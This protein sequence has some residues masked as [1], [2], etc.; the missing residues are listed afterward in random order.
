MPAPLSS[1]RLFARLFTCACLCLFAATALAVPG[2]PTAVVSLDHA[3]GVHLSWQAPSGEVPAGYR[4]YRVSRHEVPAS[5]SVPAESAW[6]LQG[7][8]TDT[9]WTQPE[10]PI[11]HSYEY[12]VRAHDATGQ[13]GPRSSRT[14][15]AR[16]RFGFV[17]PWNDTTPSPAFDFRPAHDARVRLTASGSRLLRAGQPIR[18]MGVNICGAAA[19]PEAAEAAVVA[20]RMALFGIN[21]VRFHQIDQLQPNGV[22]SDLALTQLS[23]TQMSRLGGFI[24]ALA[25][26]GIYTNLNLHVSRT[27]LSIDP[28]PARQRFKGI[29]IF[30]HLAGGEQDNIRKQQINYA[31]LFLNH[32]IPGIGR[33][34]DHPAVSIVEINNENGLI[35]QWARGNFDRLAFD[36][37]TYHG[38]LRDLWTDWLRKRYADDDALR[39]A[40]SAHTI[41]DGTPAFGT[42]LLAAAPSAGSSIAEPWE[43]QVNTSTGAAAT[44]AWVAGNEPDVQSPGAATTLRIHVS[45]PSNN[46]TNHHVQLLRK[47]LTLNSSVAHTLRFHGKVADGEPDRSF[48]AVLRTPSGS[49][50][51]SIAE[52]RL[53][54]R[55]QEFTVCFPPT[56]GSSFNFSLTD[57]ASRTG[58]IYLCGFSLSVG[59]S[60]IGRLASTAEPEGIESANL[61]FSTTQTGPFNFTSTSATSWTMPPDEAATRTFVTDGRSPG[62]GSLRFSV[63]PANVPTTGSA[64]V[65]RVIGSSS[66]RF[67]EPYQL[68]FDAK[69]PADST[70]T[71]NGQLHGGAFPVF[72]SATFTGTGD[73]QTY[74]LTFIVSD[75]TT[76]ARRIGFGLGLIEGD[77]ELA[78]IYVRRGGLTGLAEGESIADEAFVQPLTKNAFYSRFRSVQ[79]DWLAFLWDTELTYWQAMRNHVRNTIKTA[80][81]LPPIL[82]LGTQ[83]LMSPNLLQE[84][85]GFDVIDDHG[86]WQHPTSFHAPWHTYNVPMTGEPDL[87]ANTIAHRA[88]RRIVGK[89]YLI[90]EYAHPAP[91]T[92]GTEG[93]PLHG[94][95]GA[96]QGWAGVFGFEYEHGRDAGGMTWRHEYEGWLTIARAPAKMVTLPAARAMLDRG[97]IVSEHDG[98]LSQT[99]S[100]T[101]TDATAQEMIRQTMKA[102][103]GAT[104][105]GIAPEL[106]YRVPI[107]MRRGPVV[108]P[109]DSRILPVLPAAPAG[110]VESRDGALRWETSNARVLIRSARS[111]AAIGQLPTDASLNL[112]HGVS[113]AS[114][115]PKLQGSARMVG[116][117]RQAHSERNWACFVLTRTDSL[118]DAPP[119]AVGSR[120]LLTTT[121]FADNHFLRWVETDTLS[122][123]PWDNTSSI[124]DFGRGPSFV[125][126]I[127]GTLGFP[128][129]DG[130][131]LARELDAGGDLGPALAVAYSTGTDGARVATVALPE[132]PETL[133]Y[134][135]EV[136]PAPPSPFEL[137]RNSHFTTP[138]APGAAPEADPD[139]DGLRNLAEYAFGLSPLLP[140][141]TEDR[142]AS[143]TLTVDGQ[144]YLTL[145]VRRRGDDP[146]LRCIA[147]SSGD[148]VAWDD[149]GILL[150]GAIDHGDGTKTVVYRDSVP[151]APGARRFLRL[152]F[153]LEP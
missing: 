59:N 47:S 80:P 122:Q 88:G 22:F 124:R 57:F 7:A 35:D 144:T 82:L 120:W 66:L 49:V 127:T 20:R 125:E 93:F 48:R 142:L 26:E 33:L 28:K 63:T 112:G 54:S 75:S 99:A 147:Q 105:F 30:S 90:S 64:T 13:E 110:A 55:W 146:A 12:T 15:F 24:D 145:T 36:F 69:A 76:T 6:Q 5:A 94:A 96:L 40:W 34:R 21:L 123:G 83:G 101:I 109:A 42:E 18:F 51:Y 60:I 152:R 103:I 133:W 132:R 27:Y 53:T 116:P 14:V 61:L 92:Y 136:V 29:A 128:V 151:L 97:H 84:A 114:T 46:G 2:A 41:P 56:A 148:L 58:H 67:G 79:R 86:Y 4:I 149:D 62:V 150:A 130:L 25:A 43:L 108:R 104:D 19:F 72:G 139:G 143:G 87:G 113:L 74:T 126:R 117:N 11:D 129:P 71:A 16:Q 39:A 140:T 102:S 95:Y 8:T 85:A 141:G 121:G 89:P 91:N 118:G 1:S 137:W 38:E 9:F 45:Q 3:E 135:L 81:G 37:P 50:N 111:K 131:L 138:D 10:L 77:F 65:L 98:T 134:T 153:S 78:N 119:G 68:Q 106:A 70:F 31:T 107:G 23:S 115:A 17:L 100:V 73:W 32:S 44:G 52:L